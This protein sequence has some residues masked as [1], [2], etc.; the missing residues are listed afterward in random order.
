VS[1]ARQEPDDA[2]HDPGV[3]EDATLGG[4]FR[5]HDRPPAFGGSDGHPYTVSVE[6]ENT[7]DLRAPCEAY[8]VFLRWAQN[9]V[10]IVGHL[11]TA[12]LARGRTGPDAIE[13]VGRLTLLEVQGLLEEAIAAES[14]QGRGA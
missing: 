10:G 12:T 13:E 11:E 3:S 1:E 8:L 4:Y 5:V 14:V 6:V 7:P 9:G 2:H